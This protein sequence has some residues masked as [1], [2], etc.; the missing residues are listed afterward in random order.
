M[1]VLDRQTVRQRLDLDAARNAVRAAFIAHAQ[2][3]A[4]PPAVL[5]LDLGARRGDVHV[6]GAWLHG[7]TTYTVKIASSFASAREHGMPSSQGLSLVFDAT[8]GAPLALL[9]DGGWLTDV[10]TGAAGAV[11][12]D[13]L[14]P[15][16]VERLSIL[17]TGGQAFA[18]L[19]ALSRVRRPGLVSLWGRNP[20]A[21]HDLATYVR[22]ELAL[23]PEVAETAEAAVRNADVVVTVTAAR[24]PLFGADAVSSNALVLAV[25]ADSPGKQELDPRLLTNAG[26]VVV[27]DATQCSTQGELQYAPPGLASASLG[28]LLADPVA[29]LRRG[30]LIVVDLTGL[31]VQDA[32]VASLLFAGNCLSAG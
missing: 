19:R 28:A 24:A 2:A 30:E 25:G 3:A 14:A 15:P 18:Q 32:A 6:K 29:G 21:A 20:G 10:R 4:T 13:L 17:G 8:S 11:A 22:D 1:I 7:S 23:T 9:N 12:V 31:G 5:H 26:L 16:M 27:D